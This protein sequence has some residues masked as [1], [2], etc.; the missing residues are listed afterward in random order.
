MAICCRLF[1]LCTLVSRLTCSPGAVGATGAR[2]SRPRSACDVPENV[3]GFSGRRVPPCSWRG[4]RV[5]GGDD[6]ID[7][8]AGAT[9]MS[10]TAGGGLEQAAAHLLSSRLREVAHA[11]TGGGF[12]ARA[13]A[14][15]RGECHGEAERDDAEQADQ[16]WPARRHGRPWAQ[17]LRL[18]LRGG[19]KGGC[20]A[21]HLS[22]KAKGRHFLVT[23]HSF[24]NLR[25]GAQYAVERGQNSSLAVVGVKRAAGASGGGTGTGS[26]R[27]T[28]ADDSDSLSSWEIEEQHAQ[29][30]RRMATEREVPAPAGLIPLTRAGAEQFGAVEM[31]QSYMGRPIQV[32]LWSFA[33]NT[34]SRAHAVTDERAQSCMGR[35]MQLEHRRVCNTPRVL[36]HA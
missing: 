6:M 23:K 13:G 18:S 2:L 25:A 33:A 1:L 11:G 29:M 19:G 5:T 15:Q 3:A 28:D 10:V 32:D 12:A 24:P 17:P 30:R 14:S 22:G 35:P 21:K 20:K 8:Q 4:T 34:A 26:F 27:A 16:R 9:G 36:S 7:E 31:A